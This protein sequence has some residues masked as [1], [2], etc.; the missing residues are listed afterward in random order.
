MLG[1]RRASV[2]EAASHLQERNLI[3]YSHG[4]IRITDRTGLED[5]ACEC[6]TVVKERFDKFLL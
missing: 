2:S 5:F 3:Q 6:Y 4:H 1:V